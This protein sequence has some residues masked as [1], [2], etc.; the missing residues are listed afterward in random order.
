MPGRRFAEP[1]PSTHPASPRSAGRAS[2][3][4]SHVPITS[5]ARAG[6]SCNACKRRTS[7][8]PSRSRATP[9]YGR[10]SGSWSRTRVNESTRTSAGWHSGSPFFPSGSIKQCPTSSGIFSLPLACLW[11]AVQGDRRGAKSPASSMPRVLRSRLGQCATATAS[12]SGPAPRR[13]PAPA[14]A[15]S[16]TTSRRSS[17]AGVRPGWRQ[18]SRPRAPG[19]EEPDANRILPDPADNPGPGRPGPGA[20]LTCS[21]ASGSPPARPAATSSP[22]PAPRSAASGELPTGPAPSATSRR[23]AARVTV[24]VGLGNVANYVVLHLVDVLRHRRDRIH[25]LCVGLP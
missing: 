14:R 18:P 3:S 22:P 11:H 21:A 25:N 2:W 6:R 16:S 13:P 12:S 4:T 23:A 17:L 8:L 24:H 7:S 9:M 20:R 1:P 15:A 19:S 5:G 10:W